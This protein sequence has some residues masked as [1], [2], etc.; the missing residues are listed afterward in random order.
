MTL[1]VN[2]YYLDKEGNEIDIP[3]LPESNANELA[4]VETSRKEFYGS[5][6]SKSLGLKILTRLKEQPFI[7]VE[8]RNIDDLE[9]EVK[10]LL[11]NLDKFSDN[12]YWAFRLNNILCAIQKS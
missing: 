5:E 7:A 12:G 8:R 2:A 9:S 3:F 4:G 11:D 1:S 10:L 6:I